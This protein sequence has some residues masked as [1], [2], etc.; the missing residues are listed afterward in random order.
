MA[1]TILLRMAALTGEA[2]YR[3]AAEAALGQVVGVAPRQPTFFGQWLV[4]LDL[5]LA[6]VAE[7]AVVGAPDDPST[8]A[9]VAVARRGHRPHQVLA[10]SGQ[11]DASVIP[12]LHGRT[13]VDGRPAAY[14]CQNFACRRPVTAPAELAALLAQPGSPAP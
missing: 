12:L 11:P 14:V 6:A 3:D 9:L 2:A 10:V 7:V 4:A 13:V 1:S 8:Q 5:A